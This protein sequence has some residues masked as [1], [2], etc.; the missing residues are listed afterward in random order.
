MKF[1]YICPKC[2]SEELYKGLIEE[3]DGVWVQHFTCLECDI[4]IYL[5]YELTEIEFE[6]VQYVLLRDLF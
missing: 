2:G 3:E 4:D 6:G 1:N 5:K